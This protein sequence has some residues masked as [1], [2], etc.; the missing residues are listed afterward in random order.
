MLLRMYD[1]LI[2]DFNNPNPNPPLPFTC[3]ALPMKVR[4]D[5]CFVEVQLPLSLRSDKDPTLGA[6]VYA[7]TFA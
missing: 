3:L 6:S 1:D 4:W 2:L 5:L 7:H